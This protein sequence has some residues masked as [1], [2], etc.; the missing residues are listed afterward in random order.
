MEKLMGKNSLSVAKIV[1]I[2]ASKRDNVDDDVLILKMDMNDIAS[3]KSYFEKVL[4]HF[5]QVR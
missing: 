2:S 4:T 3:H 5:G 1:N